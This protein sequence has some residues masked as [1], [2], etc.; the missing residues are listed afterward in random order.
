[1]RKKIVSIL[2]SSII[3]FSLIGI[4]VS[5]TYAAENQNGGQVVTDG[6]ITFYEDSTEPTT[7]PTTEPSKPTPSTPS[8]PKVEKPVGRYPSTGELIKGSIGLSGV[9]LIVIAVF[10]FL[11]KRKKE[12]EADR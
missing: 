8:E 11:K 2:L 10:F 9:A 4:S 12:T 5:D 3:G 6:I 1:M 7:E